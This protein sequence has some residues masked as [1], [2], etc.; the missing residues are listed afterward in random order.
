MLSIFEKL[1][2]SEVAG[3]AVDPHRLGAS[4]GMR[5]ELSRI[6]SKLAT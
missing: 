5:T 2:G 1:D 4:Q 6:M 3:P